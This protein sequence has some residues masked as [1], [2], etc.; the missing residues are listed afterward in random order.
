M[1]RSPGSPSQMIAALLRRA[2]AH[3]AVEAVDAGVELAADEPLRVRRL[4]V[5][6]LRPRLRSTRARRRSAAQNASGSRSARVVDAG[7]GDAALRAR[8]SVGRRKA[9]ALRAAERRSRDGR[10][11]AMLA[12]TRRR[13]RGRRRLALGGGW[14]RRRRR[15]LPEDRDAEQRAEHAEHGVRSSSDHDSRAGARCRR[16]SMQPR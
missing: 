1:R 4:P 2:V 8:Q 14:R 7:V 9:R 3:V 15:R 5:E 6:H 10:L 13:E 16:R 11:S 12:L